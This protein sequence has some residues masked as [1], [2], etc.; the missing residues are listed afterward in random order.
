[1]D[2]A[3]EKR[4]VYLAILGLGE[5]TIGPITQK[6]GVT[7]SKTYSILE[8]LKKKGLVTS[9]IKQGTIYFQVLNPNRILDYL[10][11]KAKKITEEKAEIKK[12][13]PQLISKQKPV[14]RQYATVYETFGGIKT[15]YDEMLEYEKKSGED[16]ICF[17][18]GEEYQNDEANLFFMQYDR[19][20]KEAGIK[21]R[22]IG[23]E[24]QRSFYKK[25][26][27]AN[28]NITFRFVKQAIPTGVLIFGDN[29][30]TLLWKEV[31]TAFVIHSK[32]NADVY[33]KFYESLWKIA[34]R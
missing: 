19:K 8:K 9:I 32:Q 3:K 10:D 14:E 23:L 4:K 25:T 13:L 18:L 16:F 22:I 11:E 21:T 5:S 12:L 33:K 7:A 26:F 27:G 20:R 17:T 30:A 34:K 28:P 24:E 6:A 29:V 1:M 31:P 2:L 15:L